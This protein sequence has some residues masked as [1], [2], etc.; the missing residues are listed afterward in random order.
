MREELFGRL[1]ERQ[2]LDDL[3]ADARGGRSAVLVLRGE[4][5]IGKT[6]LLKYLVGRSTGCHIVRV[7]GVQAEIELS[8]AGLHQLCAPLLGGLDRLPGPQR[9][10]LSAAFGLRGGEAPD[11]FLVGLAALSLLANAAGNQPVVCVVDDAQWLDQVSAQTLGFVAR[12]LLAE[13]ILLVFAV[14]EPSPDETFGGLPELHLTGLT[15]SDS[16]ALL[17]SAV[18]GPLDERVR[19]RIVAETRGNPLALL[20][21]PHELSN[22]ELAGG[23]V[24]PDARPLSSQLEH[25]FLRRVQAL[26]AETQR[27]LF[28]AAA[29]PFGDLPLVRRA[30][31]RL[32]ISVDAAVSQ[33]EASGLIALDG[34]LRFRHPLV[35]SAAYRAAETEDRREV[36]QALAD[37]TDARVDPDRRAWHLARAASGP[38]ESVAA[39]LEQSADRARARGGVAAAAAFLERAAGLTPEPVRRAARTLAAALAKYQA[40]AFSAALELADAAELGPLDE[41][42]AAKVTLLRGE[43]RSISTSSSAGLPLLLDAAKRL[44]QLDAG[45]ARAT[46]RDALHAGINADGLTGRDTVAVAAAV[47][48]APR[49]AVPAPGEL[50]LDGVATAA[51]QGYSAGVPMLQEALAAFRAGEVPAEEALGWLPLAARMA[52]DTWDSTGWTVLTTSL[53]ELAR[54]TGALSVLPLALLLQVPN[55][56]FAGELDAAESLAAQ[57]VAVGEA[58][59]A[60][61]LGPYGSLFVE[62]FRGREAATQRA[63]DTL[64]QTVRTRGQPKVEQDTLWAAAVLYNGLGRYDEAQPAARRASADPDGLGLS[65]KAVPEFVE[66]S[67]RLGRPGD[68]LDAVR[69]LGEMAEAT[70]TDWALGTAAYVRALVSEQADDLYREAIERLGRT[71]MRMDFARARL[72]YGEWLRRENRRTDARAELG[73]AHELLSGFGAAGFAERARRELLAT[74]ATVRRRTQASYE[75]LTPQEEQIARLAGDG[76]TNAEIGARLFVSPHTVDWHLRKVFSKLGISSRRQLRSTLSTPA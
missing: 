28:I 66:A 59:G 16:R 7:T 26:P 56:A 37:A 65:V 15:E 43:I 71:E 62:P 49:P 38:D 52:G 73:A 55:R 42:G 63:M 31:E 67:A 21:L 51:T 9:G 22:A 29:E 72:C 27:L 48:A 64:N 1:A 4:A 76:L 45:L 35:R 20:E 18:A 47:L 39:E 40:G 34:R 13:S 61:F 17:E 60:G 36:H 46:Y 70:G 14:R 75:S 25:G 33:A 44:E 50:L 5:G 30:A 57:V 2:T 6:E 32:G 24:L 68:A 3:L 12:R 8:Y 11:R 10:A 54:E 19:D 23:F 74:G 41:L 53:A 58:T 69:K